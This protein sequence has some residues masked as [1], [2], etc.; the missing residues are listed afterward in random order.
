MSSSLKI[1]S[2]NCQ[3]LGNPLTVGRLQ[4]LRKRVDPDVIFLLEMKNP[5]VVVLQK[6]ESLGY[7]NHAFVSPHGTASGGLA[8]LWKQEI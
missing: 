1:L 4:E 5:D 3:G 2:W 7:H 8:L 6:V